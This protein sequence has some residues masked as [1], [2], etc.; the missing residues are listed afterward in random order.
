MV[1]QTSGWQSVAV[2]V[3]TTGAIT[4][5]APLPASVADPAQRC[6]P[7]RIVIAHLGL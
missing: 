4:E 2:D 6:A 3:V 5:A 7:A 1:E